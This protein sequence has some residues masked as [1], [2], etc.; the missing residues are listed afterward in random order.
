MSGWWLASYL[1]LWSLVALTLLILLVV[2]RQLGLIYIQSGSG[3][4]RLDEGPALGSP[5]PL[6]DAVDE[7]SGEPFT[8]P[9]RKSDFSLLVFTSPT[10]SICEEAVRGI[11][12]LARDNDGDVLVISDREGERNDRLRALIAAPARFIT[13][14]QRHQAM[15]IRSTPQAL[16][17]DGKGVVLDKTIVNRFEHLQELLDRAVVA[18]N[19]TP[20]T[21]RR[22]K[23][24]KR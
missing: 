4:I 18:T 22:P 7:V 23:V 6:I 20:A 19:L 14:E 3:G 24:A 17:I 5:I 12:A 1:F 15:G 11:D 13:S 21:P 2:L 10:C 9:N 16:V 8:F